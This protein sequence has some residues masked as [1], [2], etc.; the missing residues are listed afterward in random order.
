MSSPL[1]VLVPDLKRG[2][3]AALVTVVPFFLARELGRPEL[4]WTALGGWFA[5]LAD[6]GGVT[7]SRARAMLTFLAV[8]TGSVALA[9]VVGR[10]EIG[11][12]ACITAATFFGSMARVFGNVPAT[13]GT[14]TAISV[15]VSTG[16]GIPTAGAPGMF[17]LG[18][19]WQI[20]MSSLVWP[21]APERPA[22][23]ALAEVYARLA[24][25]AD[26]IAI[27][28]AFATGAEDAN[29]AGWPE[30]ARKHHRDVRS[31]IEAAR[32]L[33]VELRARRAGETVVGANARVLLGDAE[34]EFFRLIAYADALEAELGKA[35]IVDEL[36]VLAVLRDR[37]H[38]IVHQLRTRRPQ[39]GPAAAL[40]A[41]A[42]IARDL[43]RDLLASTERALAI[44]RDLDAVPV[45]AERAL[46]RPMRAIAARDVL[47]WRSPIFQHA[48]RATI[49][50]I[51]ATVVGR[52][53]SPHHAQWVTITTIAVVQPYLGPTLKRVLERVIGT[54]VGVAVALILIAMLASPLAITMA[55]FVL[56]VLSVVT[57]P[58]SYRLYIAFLTPVFLLVAD[59]GHPGFGTA[60]ARVGDVVLGGAVAVF[61]AFVSPSWEKRH[62]PAQ[63][64]AAIAA[65]S[66]YVA[67]ATDTLQHG[68]D[69]AP[70]TAA[71]RE[72]GATLEAA[73]VSLERALAEP[74]PLR[75]DT[76][77]A[78]FI[79]TNARRLAT[80]LTAL[81]EA[82]RAR[83][84]TSPL[85]GV[86]AARVYVLAVL[87]ATA[88]FITTGERTP[89]TAPPAVAPA[90][91]RLV[92]HAELLASGQRHRR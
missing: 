43:T 77:S 57:R 21:T 65:L 59:H 13:I 20:A 32:A 75:W 39:Q 92:H 52:A 24:E 71:R 70:L 67:V 60:L 28:V 80:A 16:A 49:A 34:L 11:A 51:V 37:W 64:S 82:R 66:R 40:P 79:L 85:A 76:A 45:T 35:S 22:L 5:A 72:V 54:I 4:V 1:A 91:V 73:E 50:A 44:S 26:A 55:M 15:A 84:D 33:L 3:R 56:A 6:P 62:L 58:R 23:R 27:E 19:L 83:S 86:A 89:P 81:D 8:A 53:L 25:F 46:E 10:S 78:V 14:L 9:T 74:R 87:D 2:V 90:L 63:L 7:R 88:R 38:T 17:A 42:V 18:V 30:L 29:H 48:V 36:A 47:T 12:L 61:A 68:G 41:D 31:S 69:R